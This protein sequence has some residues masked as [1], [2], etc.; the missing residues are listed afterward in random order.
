M[1]EEPSHTVQGMA[2]EQDEEANAEGKPEV[3]VDRTFAGEEGGEEAAV[4]SG[5]GK[6]TA[7][8]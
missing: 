8:A 7:V 5:D 4:A 1:E 2:K 3:A 6:G